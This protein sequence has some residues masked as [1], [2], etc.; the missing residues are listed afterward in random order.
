MLINRDHTFTDLYLPIDARQERLLEAIDGKRRIRDIGRAT[1][2]P[3]L[4]RAFF[5]QLWRWDQIVFST[6]R[7]PDH[8]SAE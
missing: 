6:A 1:A 7:V 3:D 4:A 5:E 2:D 8:E